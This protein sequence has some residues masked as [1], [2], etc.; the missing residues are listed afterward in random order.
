MKIVVFIISILTAGLV[1][2]GG[3]TLS[4]TDHI[5]AFN[6]AQKCY[7]STPK[8]DIHRKENCA[9]K[10]LEEGSFLFEPNSLNIAA[11][12][13]N[14]G[15]ALKKTDKN[16]SYEV[17]NSALGLYEAIYGRSS[18][19]IID[20]LIDSGNA[21]R[22][23]KIAKQH[24]NEDS[25]DYAGILIEISM[26]DRVTL[27]TS[28]RYARLAQNIYIREEGEDS[29]SASMASFQQGKVKFAQK[30]YRSAI[31]LLEA[32][33]HNPVIAEYAHSW[34]VQAYDN[35]G[36][37]ESGTFH[38]QQLGKLT[39]FR[40]ESEFIPLFVSPPEY[41]ERAQRYGKEGYAVLELMITEEGLTENHKI[42]EEYPESQGFGEAALKA[43]LTLRYAPRVIDGQP[44]EVPGVLYKYTF[45]MAPH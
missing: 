1:F 30:K 41:P 6:E 23:L 31:P 35:R 32:A 15:R 22:A 29:L 39:S 10:A 17:L 21:R 7:K 5:K 37:L 18:L 20:I 8:R 33:T 25:T 43:A 12:T 14:F 42:I 13:Y 19:E 11:L 4:R 24:F 2:S 27:D 45:K 36:D 34:L 40:N 9:E 28:A 26:S 16:R 3:T 38:A 44:Q